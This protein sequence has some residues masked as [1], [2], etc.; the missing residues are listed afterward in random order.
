VAHSD[1]SNGNGGESAEA[2]GGDDLS[3][4]GVNARMTFTPGVTNNTLTLISLNEYIVYAHCNRRTDGD[5]VDLKADRT[6]ILEIDYIYTSSGT[7]G[8]YVVAIMIKPKATVSGTTYITITLD[9]S[10]I[11]K[12][13]R[14]RYIKL[15]V[16]VPSDI[17]PKDSQVP[18][19]TQAYIASSSDPHLG[20]STWTLGRTHTW[21]TSRTLF[22]FATTPNEFTR[23]VNLYMDDISDGKVPLASAFVERASEKAE[24][25]IQGLKFPIGDH[26]IYF[27]A[28]G[29]DGKENKKDFKTVTLNIEEESPHVESVSIAAINWYEYQFKIDVNALCK[30]VNIYANGTLVA[31]KSTPTAGIH[32]AKVDLSEYSG[33][34]VYLTFFPVDSNMEEDILFARATTVTLEDV[35][36]RITSANVIEGTGSKQGRY[37]FTYTVDEFCDRVEIYDNGKYIAYQTTNKA[38]T[39]LSAEFR[40]SPGEH[41]LVFRP[42]NAKTSSAWNVDNDPMIVIVRVIVPV[43]KADIF[44]A[45]VKPYSGVAGVTKFKFTY[46]VNDA[47]WRVYLFKNNEYKESNLLAYQTTSGEYKRDDNTYE[48]DDFIFWE[49]GYHAIKILAYGDGEEPTYIE[50]PTKIVPNQIVTFKVT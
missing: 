29:Y 50:D 42:T 38:G 7:S 21:G 37:R 8:D 13:D 31:T 28:V 14:F 34:T 22:A 12:S 40:L 3:A 1:G 9:V 49:K 17:I 18:K 20:K 25:L 10:E 4:Q 47:C 35:F 48:S 16:I 39:Y 36:P 24:V 33:E 19:I 2:S 45:T 6:D 30:Q 44:L 23:S 46:V 43:R 26:I 27:T 41:E 15:K 11:R 32:I 5:W